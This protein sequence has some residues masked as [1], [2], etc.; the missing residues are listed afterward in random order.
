MRPRAAIPDMPQS[1]CFAF[2]VL[3]EQ[4]RVGS[5]LTPTHRLSCSPPGGSERVFASDA[6]QL[7]SGFVGDADVQDRP[8]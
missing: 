4:A 5:R 1:T 2:C 8:R 7:G 3:A 6:D